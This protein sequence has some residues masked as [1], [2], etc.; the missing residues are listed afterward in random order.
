MGLNHDASVTFFGATVHPSPR[1]S[2]RHGLVQHADLD[3]TRPPGG[4]DSGDAVEARDRRAPARQAA[5]IRHD[6]SAVH[7]P[8][9]LPIPAPRKNKWAGR[10]AIDSSRPQLC[11]A[12]W[13]QDFR[14]TGI[15]VKRDQR[16]ARVRRAFAHQSRFRRAAFSKV[17]CGTVRE[18]KQEWERR[19][20]TCLTWSWRAP[21]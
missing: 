6:R 21:R 19:F 7:V 1:G 4:I 3:T 17:I 12:R 2:V 18:F 9:Q 11:I 8:V 20:A 16:A 10:C 5:I 13:K 15:A 14:R